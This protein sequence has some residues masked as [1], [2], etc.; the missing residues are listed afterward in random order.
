MHRSLRT[1]ENIFHILQPWV[2]VP[3]LCKMKLQKG[4]RIRIRN[5]EGNKTVYLQLYISLFGFK[6]TFK[7]FI[8]VSGCTRWKEHTLE[9]CTSGVLWQLWLEAAQEECVHGSRERAESTLETQR[10]NSPEQLWLSTLVNKA[11]ATSEDLFFSN[12]F[13]NTWERNRGRGWEERWQLNKPWSWVCAVDDINSAIIFNVK[14]F[15]TYWKPDT[16]KTFISYPTQ[17]SVNWYVLKFLSK[18]KIIVESVTAILL[19]SM[20]HFS[21]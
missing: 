20:K 21:S 13:T 4:T 12:S 17:C 11:W 10:E 3:S 5:E 1:S 16:S 6:A 9:T 14:L 8:L 18:W 15:K 2:R 19:Y 7:S